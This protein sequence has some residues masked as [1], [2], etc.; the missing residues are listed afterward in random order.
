MAVIRVQTVQELSRLLLDK[1]RRRSF[2]NRYAVSQDCWPLLTRV[3]RRLQ[4][5]GMGA[6]DAGSL[7][8]S[9]TP[10]GPQSAGQAEGL[11]FDG[12]TWTVRSDDD[13][14]HLI[15][16][17]GARVIPAPTPPPKL[18]AKAFSVGHDGDDLYWFVFGK[19]YTVYRY[20]GKLQDW[21]EYRRHSNG[22]NPDFSA[23]TNLLPWNEGWLTVLFEP[24]PGPLG[25]HLHRLVAIDGKFRIRAAT[26]PFTLE[27]SRSD[28]CCTGLGHDESHTGVLL[29]YR[30]RGTDRRLWLE[31]QDISSRLLPTAAGRL[32]FPEAGELRKRRFL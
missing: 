3:A 13:G 15:S 17:D 16:N 28:A 6:T 7:F 32:D 21:I 11:V 19:P 29:Q 31:N 24:N 10:M 2:L 27:R 30:H 25:V 14:S 23:A 12:H 20:S 5:M 1:S 4:G 8:S 18:G 9:L 22:F 26:E